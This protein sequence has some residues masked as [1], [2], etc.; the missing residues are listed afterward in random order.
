[1]DPMTVVRIVWRH[2]YIALPFAVLAGALVVGALFFGPRAY[3]ASS[4][5]AM[6][7][8]SLP[9]DL[10]IDAD[11]ELGA[12]ADNPYLR[13]TDPTLVLEVGRT[14]LSSEDVGSILENEGLS[15]EFTVGQGL[16][17]T[18]Q[19]LTITASA[20]DPAVAVATAARLGELLSVQ[21]RDA[22]SV[23]GASPEFMITIQ[24][25][26]I[27]TGA[28]ERVS[29]RLRNAAVA[30]IGGIV[31][32][33]GAISVARALDDR[34]RTPSKPPVEPSTR[35][36]P[37]DGTTSTLDLRRA[38][39]VSDDHEVTR[40]VP[41]VSA[42]PAPEPSLPSPRPQT[43][44]ATPAPTRIPA[45]PHGRPTTTPTGTPIDRVDGTGPN[46]VPARESA[47]TRSATTVEPKTSTRQRPP[48]M[49]SVIPARRPTP[50]TT[51]ALT[52]QHRTPDE[53]TTTTVTR[54]RTG[55]SVRP[56]PRIGRP[57]GD[58]AD[59]SARTRDEA[60]RQ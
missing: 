59:R 42:L 53:T 5:Y 55:S 6:I 47:T 8:P 35:T 20:P 18:A 2:K 58:T 43:P 13:S 24:P 23:N 11:P 36:R 16:A 41:V 40:P 38:T 56:T 44:A 25:I 50:A 10:A 29:S 19:I 28:V 45:R 7:T 27:P 31:L 14:R 22:Q 54:S 3:Q 60:D 33:V 32:L 30:G 37:D 34:R 4:S 12:R 1:M 15:T 21:V 26:N 39:P 9:S 48:S 17:T 49:P 52:V 46:P 57:N 51:P